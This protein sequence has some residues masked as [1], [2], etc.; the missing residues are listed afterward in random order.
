V[1]EKT[2]RGDWG[3]NLEKRTMFQSGTQ[4]VSHSGRVARRTGQYITLKKGEGGGT[5]F[6]LKPNLF[7]PR[8]VSLRKSPGGERS[9]NRKH[10]KNGGKNGVTW[11]A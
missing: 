2:E 4:G 10:G 9:N 11:G 7:E 8:T 5:G 3:K 6:F 1:Y